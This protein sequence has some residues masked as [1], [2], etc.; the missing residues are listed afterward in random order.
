MEIL[1][2]VILEFLFCFAS[3]VSILQRRNSTKNH[4]QKM[5]IGT[6][7]C[8]GSPKRQPAMCI[9]EREREEQK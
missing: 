9:R 3:L 6:L 2:E 7:D 4:V 1:S 8:E 5:D